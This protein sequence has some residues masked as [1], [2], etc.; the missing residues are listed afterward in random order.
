MTEHEKE[1]Y[2]RGG[3]WIQ[4]DRGWWHPPNCLAS[5]PVDAAVEMARRDEKR[6][7]RM[8]RREVEEYLNGGG[9]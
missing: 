3:G 2:L 6:G 8:D 1:A 7:L 9:E 5:W 4:N